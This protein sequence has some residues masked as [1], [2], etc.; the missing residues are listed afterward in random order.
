MFFGG[1]VTNATGYQVYFPNNVLATNITD[2]TITNYNLAVGALTSGV[3]YTWAWTPPTR[4]S[5]RHDGDVWS[6]TVGADK[7]VNFFPAN[8][9]TGCDDE[10][11]SLGRVTNATGYQ[12]YFI[13]KRLVYQ[14]HGQHN[15]QL[16]CRR[17]DARSDVHL[18]RG[19]H[20]QYVTGVTTGD[21]W[22]SPS[23]RTSGQS[24]SHEWGPCADE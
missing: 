24:E 8:G 5:R 19:Y 22:S 18:A 20:N 10:S 17:A 15:N 9:A 1:R 14:H 3:T 21:V 2:N 11:S 23:A 13:N 12:V 7:A 4:T 16:Q 6:F